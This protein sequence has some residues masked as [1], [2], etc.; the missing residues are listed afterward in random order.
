MQISMFQARPQSKV[1]PF[2]SFTDPPLRG[3]PT[4]DPAKL[5][6]AASRPQ[7]ARRDKR[8]P[9]EQASLEFLPPVPG[10]P[11]TLATTVEAMIFCEEPVATVLHRTIAAAIDWAMVIIAYGLFLLVFHLMGGDFVFTKAN[12][13]IF[14][15]VLPLLALLY[16]SLWAYAAVETPGMRWTHLRLTTFDGFQP[17]RRQRLFRFAGSALSLCTVVGLLWV[18][19]DEEHLTWQ[20]HISRTFPTP[21]KVDSKVFHRR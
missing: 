13:L 9:D 14:A 11:R 17:E 7:S 3:R 8:P 20:D 6:A 15:A 1:I 18:F 2:D 12:R 19:A 5:P 10:K 21:K 4:V 16:G